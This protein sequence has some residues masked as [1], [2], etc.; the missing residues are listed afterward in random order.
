MSERGESPYPSVK[1]EPLGRATDSVRLL[2]GHGFV[3]DHPA[4]SDLHGSRRS[5]GLPLE[6]L[7]DYSTDHLIMP[8]LR[9]LVKERLLQDIVRSVKPSSGWKVVVCDAVT[10]RIVSAACR[11][12]DIME[13][14][15]TLVEKIDPEG[16]AKRQPLSEM[17][18]IYII[19]PTARSIDALC[20]DFKDA[21]RP[22]YAAVHLFITSKISD[23]LFRKLRT[24]D[25]L[26]KRIRTVKEV[27][28][29][30]LAYEGSE[31]GSTFLFDPP[32]LLRFW[33]TGGAKT[34]EEL[35][36]SLALLF[37]PDFQGK[38]EAAIEK[39]RTMV[40]VA[41]E[42]AKL[43]A[44][45]I[46]AACKSGVIKAMVYDLLDVEDGDRIRLKAEGAPAADEGSSSGAK[47]GKASGSGEREVVLGEND[48]LW[49]T[50]RHSHVAECMNSVVDQF[51]D[52]LKGRNNKAAR[53]SVG[54]VKELSDMME[55]I[56]SLP[57]AKELLAK[58][59][60]AK[61]RSS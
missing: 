23:D 11:M 16:K 40:Q 43:A 44:S 54:E 61:V 41:A 27:Y 34:Q 55:A 58:E 17:E 22:Q 14:G 49:Q 29:E 56:R 13:E 15:V 28:L 30:F 4:H 18:A 52:Y 12:Y 46:D 6:D 59:L 26:I 57:Q 9:E 51:N 32:D 3:S 5:I 8:S 50:L 33:G 38:R 7:P 53:A 21:K 48:A 24:C 60:L 35:P 45:K 47:K 1:Y 31:K 39:D 20:E 10:L 19:S 42:L 36:D 37:S 25:P 2:D